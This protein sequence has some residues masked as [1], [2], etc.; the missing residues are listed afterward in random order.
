MSTMK[1]PDNDSENPPA[2]PT[3]EWH[4]VSRT[5]RPGDSGMSLRDWF[6]GQAMAALLGSATNV[7][8]LKRAMAKAKCEYA[9]DLFAIN[10]YQMADAM[11]AARKEAP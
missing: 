9:E 4:E 5:L 10:S 11:L 8:E 2:F 3:Q 6:A 1:T 7:E